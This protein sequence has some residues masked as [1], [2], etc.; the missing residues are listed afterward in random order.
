MHRRW[1]G[2]PR[3]VLIVCETSPQV[4]PGPSMFHACTTG[5]RSTLPPRSQMHTSRNRRPRCPLPPSLREGSWFCLPQPA[6]A[7]HPSPPHLLHRLY[8]RERRGASV[9]APHTKKHTHLRPA[10]QKKESKVNTARIPATKSPTAENILYLPNPSTQ[11][12]QG[13]RLRA[14][15]PLVPACF[16]P[17]MPVHVTVYTTSSVQQGSPLPRTRWPLANI[18]CPSRLHLIVLSLLRRPLPAP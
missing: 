1:C 2:L 18:R 8:T 10:T 16:G 7:H 17:L 9:L 15:V 12:T 5:T 4:S 11:P 3:P 13:R 14:C 6:S